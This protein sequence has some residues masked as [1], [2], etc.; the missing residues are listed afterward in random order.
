M[1]YI[2]RTFKDTDYDEVM[3]LWQQTDLGNPQ[4]GDDLQ[5]IKETLL[6]NGTMYLV[7]E[8]NTGKVIATAWITYD[9][10]RLYLHHFGVLPE[11]QNKGIGDMLTKKC[12]DFAKQKNKQIKLEVHQNN[13]KAI[14]LY[15]KNGFSYL[16]DYN[17]L[18]IRK[19]K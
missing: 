8:T 9:G 5:V 11:Y 3:N 16:G 18:I 13:K 4:R 19:Y 2:I 12:I 7:E 1:K 6:M 14:H 10:R 17:V 15:Q